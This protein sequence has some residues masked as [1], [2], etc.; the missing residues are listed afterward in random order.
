MVRAHRGAPT[1]AAQAVAVAALIA[2]GSTSV[3]MPAYADEFDDKLAGAQA[4]ESDAAQSVAQIETKLANVEKEAQDAQARQWTA[5]ANY[6][7]AL[8]NLVI[9]QRAVDDTDA[10]LASSRADVAKA[11]E[12][13]TSIIQSI[14]TSGGG[15]LSGLAPYLTEGGLDDV[16]IRKLAVD[17]VGTRAQAQ[18]KAYEKA[19]K[20]AISASSAAKKA[21]ATQKDYT[22]RARVA[23][24]E[25]QHVSA[26]VKGR[27]EELNAKHEELLAKLAQAR[28]VTLEAE[29][30]RQAELDR[31]AA[32]RQ[33]QVEEEA[34]A[35]VK[36][37]AEEAEIQRKAAADAAAKKAAEE[38][39]A[40]E[41]AAQQAAQQAQA[42][43]EAAKK[44]AEDAAAKKAAEEAAAQQAAEDAAKRQAEEAAREAAARKAAEEAAARKAAEQAAA[45]KAA[46]EKAA[47]EAKKRQEE[48]ARKA[49]SNANAGA[50]VANYALQFV[51]VPYVWGG[52]SP[53]GF[54]CSGLVQY[55][56]RNAIG[57]SLPRVS[58]GQGAQGYA[59]S[60]AEARIGDL[61]YYGGHVGIYLGN[62][63]MVHAPKPGD[64]V[65][66]APVYG[67]PQY[68]RLV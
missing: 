51:G 2:L 43:R 40:K 36:K 46:A 1:R 44:A 14:Y 62:G 63:Q 32:E 54:D 22:E 12:Q 3:V 37:A 17:V 64:V 52:T 67:N 61:V 66:V 27:L 23:K 13:L 26:E 7:D 58:W 49:A 5:E 38:A 9:A 24:D 41:A 8:S 56:F 55:S 65:K 59:V 34:V 19:E 21:L 28:G 11:R 53:S 68:R 18:L 31:K 60:R 39:A 4:E 15:S 16:E 30:E 10:S 20:D 29:K 42:Q 6:N 50:Q 25:A 33:R 35:A 47:A 48:A 57:K 45:Q